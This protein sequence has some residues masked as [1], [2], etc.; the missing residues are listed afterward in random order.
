[1][2]NSLPQGSVTVAP[3][4]VPIYVGEQLVGGFAPSDLEQ[5]EE[6]SFVDREEGKTQQGW[7]LRDVI[8]SHV[9]PGALRPDTT[10]DISSSSRSK[11]VQLTWAQVEDEKNKVMLDLSGR[12][13]VKAASLLEEFDTR[14][15]WVQDVDKIAISAP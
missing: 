13:T 3:G 9:E 11:S 10:I 1:M 15:E 6:A 12:G 2:L 7:L 14:D 5:L 4:G 8:L